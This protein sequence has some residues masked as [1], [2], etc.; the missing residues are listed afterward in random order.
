M[1]KNNKKTLRTKIDSLFEKE[2]NIPAVLLTIVFFVLG[3]LM[4]LSL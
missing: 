3:C 4:L 1:S 2:E